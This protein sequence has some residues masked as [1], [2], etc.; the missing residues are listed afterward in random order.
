MKE[1][2]DVH[3]ANLQGP[4][5]YFAE[6]PI[7][8]KSNSY[9]IKPTDNLQLSG[10]LIFLLCKVAKEKNLKLSKYPIYGLDCAMGQSGDQ[11][12]VCCIE[13]M[14]ELIQHL[15]SFMN[16]IGLKKQIQNRTH[17]SQQE[18]Q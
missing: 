15:K 1:S 5:I 6:N 4:G 10:K 18:T 2:F 8:S 11:I 7:Y 13:W 14:K 17:F 12:Y 9:S 3:I 16:D